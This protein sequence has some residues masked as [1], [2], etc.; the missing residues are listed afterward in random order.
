MT[1]FS[2]HPP[3]DHLVVHLSDTHLLG[4]GRQLFDRIDSVTPI[5]S[6]MERL[7]ASELPID[8][9]VFTG[10]LADRA[11]ADAY[12]RL[13]DLVEP[14]AT[15]LGAELV[16][17]MG[18]HDEREPFTE[19]LWR[20]EPTMEPRDRVVMLGDA[21]L[22]VLD[23]TVPGYHH[24][25]LTAAQL[26]WLAGELA[27]PAPHGTLL[28][29]HHPPIPT[30]IELMGLIE[31]DDQAALAAVIKGTDVRGVLAGHLHYSTFST[32]GGVPV[33][34][35]A[36]SCYNIDLVAQSS[37]ILAANTSAVSASLVHLYPEQ[38][39]FSIVPMEDVEDIT[40]YDASY[41]PMIEAMSPLERREMFSN[42]NSE[43][44]RRSDQEQSG[45]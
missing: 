17:V 37:K 9:L 2:Q 8:A 16:W 45:F 12:L 13:R 25:E 19:I 5:R 39:V 3:A 30:P 42:K 41:R 22:I 20:E 34:V 14:W 33:S 29:L 35:S 43:F 18:N 31:L 15:Q 44:N 27:T 26:T 23:S 32:F 10:D 7:V 21:R 1:A 6:L 24:G 38:V 4:S 11:E 36:A 40:S 28:A